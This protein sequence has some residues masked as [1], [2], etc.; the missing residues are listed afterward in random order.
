M[1]SDLK[2]IKAD[3]I[4][5]LIFD[6]DGTLW[7]SREVVAK[8]WNESFERL[9]PEYDIE[10]VT[11]ERLTPLFGKTMDK[12]CDALLP[13][14]PDEKRRLI[15]D[16]IYKTESEFIRR[17]P[18]VLYTGVYDTVKAL[19]EKYP[20]YIV[21]NCQKGYIDDLLDTTGLR[22]FF[23]AGLCYGD[24]GAQKNVTMRML[25]EKEGLRSPVYIG[26]TQGD[27]EAS[28]LAGVPFIWVSYGLGKAENGDFAAR[29]D[30]FP[31][32]MSL[33]DSKSAIAE[34]G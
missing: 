28:R 33:S 32:L 30:S 9:L 26:D 14:V 19:S 22:P 20:L 24:T 8:A 17:E 12:I 31:E 4:D 7:D 6:I 34:E 5:S 29:I 11:K 13:G 21:S 23:K 3:G 18:G 15:T 25:I 1:K 10:T 16:D 27:A 2:K